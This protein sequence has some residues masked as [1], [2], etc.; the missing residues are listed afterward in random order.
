MT[1]DPMTVIRLAVV[2]STVLV[3]GLAWVMPHLMRPGLYFAVTVD[4]EFRD[5]EVGRRALSRYRLVVALG[6]AAALALGITARP[7]MGRWLAIAGPP[8]LAVLAMVTGLV[9]ARR[10]VLPH[11][12][13][14]RMEREA[15][16]AERATPLPGGIV[17]QS[18]PFLL[19]AAAAGW[20][21]VHWPEMPERIP[22]HWDLAGRPDRW[23]G[24]SP[25][26]ALG[27]LFLTV[28]NCGM[29]L[30][31]AGAVSRWSRRI[32]AAGPR[33]RREESFRRITLWILLGSE[34][35]G[36]GITVWLTLAMTAGGRQLRPGPVGLLAV[37]AVGIA[38][39]VVVL[40]RAGQ[41]GSRLEPA[42]EAGAGTGPGDG[43]EDRS[44]KAGIIYWNRRD[45]AL[46]VEKRFGIGYT[47]NFGNPWSWVLL[48]VFL[49]PGFIVLL[50][51]LL[52]AGR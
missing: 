16:L 29:L 9:L 36:A 11:A 51:G 2:G 3:G 21:A 35:L 48:L 20:L 19:L 5:G 6:T 30:L 32:A 52:H 23:V 38:V 33:A 13:E 8:L 50:I 42:A 28:V 27:P 4:P 41:G 24:K 37:V 46:F 7:G 31:V 43:T 34:Y 18:G 10:L 22:I 40:V 49:A 39:M 44:W 26:A 45:P 12:A 47:L 14:P 15:R 1:D 25:A 17:G